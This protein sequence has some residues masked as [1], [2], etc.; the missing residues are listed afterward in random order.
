MRGAKKQ[1][2]DVGQG[3]KE[4]AFPSFSSFPSFPPFFISLLLRVSL[5]ISPVGLLSLLQ[6]V[7]LLLSLLKIFQEIIFKKKLFINDLY[8]KN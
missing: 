8:L 1:E 6:E 3:S 2:N 4:T 5:G 7:L